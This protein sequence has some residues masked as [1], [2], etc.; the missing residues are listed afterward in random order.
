MIPLLS[1]GTCPTVRDGGS[2][3][4]VVELRGD[5]DLKSVPGWRKTV[6][7]TLAG[8]PSVLVLD[9]GQVTFMDSMGLSLLLDVLKRT[10][11]EG[12]RTVLRDLPPSVDRLLQLSGIRDL[13]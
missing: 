7:D 4:S 8:Q 11:A 10:R 6:D 13:F 12:T 9:L 5:I 3:E 2:D 1:L